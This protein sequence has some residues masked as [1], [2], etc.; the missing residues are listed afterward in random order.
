[1]NTGI[2]G[3]TFN[4]IHYGHLRACE[5]V[6]ELMPLDKV[7]FIPSNITSNKK[8]TVINTQKR[9]EMV[10]IAT[11]DNSKFEVSDIEISRGGISF[12][13]DTL[14]ELTSIYRKDNFFFIIGTDAFSGIKN[15]KNSESLFNTNMTNFIVMNRNA[16][17]KNLLNLAEYLP[18][19]IKETAGMD[20]KNSRIVL[21][22]NKYIYFLN[23]TRMDIS[24]T[25][26]RNN[27]KMNR[28]NLYLLPKKLIDYII[29]NRL[30]L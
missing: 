8:E 7:I 27:F 19:R 11:E 5:E 18:D 26:I 3:G 30:Y 17:E 20:I 22:G 16:H 4:P 1:M 24:S 28:S 25:K 29:C 10:K 6:A 9:L 13:Y 2:F 14:R 21:S 23:V 12:F 15:W